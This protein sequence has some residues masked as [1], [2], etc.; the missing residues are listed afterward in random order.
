MVPFITGRPQVVIPGMG[1]RAFTG[2]QDHELA[3]GIPAKLLPMVMDNLFKSGGRR[4]MGQPVKPILATGLT[5]SITPGFA[6][7]RKKV[8]EKKG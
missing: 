7:L 3:V 6:F 5:E 1:D 2:V 4:N 8:G